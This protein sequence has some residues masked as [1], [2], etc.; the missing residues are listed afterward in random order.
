MYKIYEE[1]YQTLMKNINELNNCEDISLLIERLIVKMPVF[2]NLI[3]GFPVHYF[4]Y[5]DKSI[6]MFRGRPKRSR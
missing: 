6:L 2:H 1:N 4:G 3:Y 5:I